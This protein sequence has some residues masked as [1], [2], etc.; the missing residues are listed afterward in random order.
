[1]DKLIV[2]IVVLIITLAILEYI[3]FNNINIPFKIHHTENFNTNPNLHSISFGDKY[4]LSFPK[5]PLFNNRSK[6]S[7]IVPQP[8]IFKHNTLPPNPQYNVSV[9]NRT[10]NNNQFLEGEQIN[11][12]IVQ[13]KNAGTPRVFANLF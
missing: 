11:T 8:R 9:G 7:N 13:A 4:S 6:T 2:L 3:E 10:I 1:M 12:P 5:N